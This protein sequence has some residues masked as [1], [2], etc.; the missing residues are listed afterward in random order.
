MDFFT[1]VVFPWVI[2]VGIEGGYQDDPNDKGNWTGAA[3][4]VGV[5]AG[6][7][8]GISA[9]EYPNL[10][11]KN[12][13]PADALPIARAKYWNAINGDLLPPAVA[14]CVFDF[15][16]NAG[17]H[18]ACKVLQRVLG[19]PQDGVCGPQ[20]QD[21]CRLNDSHV[22]AREFTAARIA[23]YQLMSEYPVDGPD[24][25]ARANATLNRAMTC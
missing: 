9:A 6:T 7:K 3:V 13:T 23:A 18:E 8:Y 22:L 24:W 5:L 15:A 11:I 10:D 20:T 4:G 25:V 12:L 16:Y 14:L 17:P 19:L 2:G 21:A 1:A